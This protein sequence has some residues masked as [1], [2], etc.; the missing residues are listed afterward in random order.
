[1][2]LGENK[3]ISK[4]NQLNTMIHHLFAINL[5]ENCTENLRVLMSNKKFCL[6][7]FDSTLLVEIDSH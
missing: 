6:L 7:P 3:K 4:K 5:T 2:I 1:M